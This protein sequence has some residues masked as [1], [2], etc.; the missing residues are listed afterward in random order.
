LVIAELEGIEF[1][2]DYF[3]REKE[4]YFYIELEQDSKT[5]AFYYNRRG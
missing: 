4:G 5:I 3:M 1:E 2:E